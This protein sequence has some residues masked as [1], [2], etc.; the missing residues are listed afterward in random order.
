MNTTI[1]A[2]SSTNA[3]ATTRCQHLSP[4]GRR[5]RHARKDSRS[6][7]CAPHDLLEQQRHDGDRADAILGEPDPGHFDTAAGINRALTGLYVLLAEDKISPRR[8]AVLAYISSLQLRT[9]PAIE[10]EVER[11]APVPQIVFDLPEPSSA[12]TPPPKHEASADR[13]AAPMQPSHD[14]PTYVLQARAP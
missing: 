14:Q 1:S 6:R 11:D 4:S 10:Y 5:C 7:F 3:E 2:S 12:S 8:A 9:L 13:A